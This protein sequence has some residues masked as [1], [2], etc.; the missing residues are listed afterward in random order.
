MFLFL[1]PLAHSTKYGAE[2]FSR[3]KWWTASCQY[4]DSQAIVAYRTLVTNMV[5]KY[6]NNIGIQK[7]D[8]NIFF[9]LEL[10]I[11]VTSFK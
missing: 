6:V 2:M 1:S 3:S 7:S 8:T 9:L 11:I 5:W 10:L 4:W